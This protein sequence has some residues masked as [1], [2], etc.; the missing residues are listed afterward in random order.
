M[1]SGRAFAFHGY[2]LL[3]RSGS[4]RQESRNAQRKSRQKPN[5]QAAMLVSARQLWGNPMNKKWAVF[6]MAA[7]L[8]LA[9]GCGKK[10]NSANSTADNSQNA[11]NQPPATQPPP[12]PEPPPPPPKPFVVPAGTDIPVILS[13]AI[14]S[15]TANPG[16]DWQGSI[17]ADILVDNEVAI[18]KGSD[19][20]GTVVTSKKQ[21]KFKGEANLAVKITRLQV[22]GKGYMIAS[23]TYADTE[24]GKGKRTAVVTGGGAAVGALIGG[25]AGGGKGAAIGA[26]VGGGGGL[27]ASGATGGKNVEFPAESRITFKLQEAVTIDRE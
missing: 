3:A 18:P 27:A 15:R 23:S 6:A 11:A 8:G 14:N 26:A 22:H 10:D 4:I 1:V 2:S 9:A 20:T 19:V 13:S 7:T 16:D 5:I 24:K 21:G 25:L 12:A 17:A